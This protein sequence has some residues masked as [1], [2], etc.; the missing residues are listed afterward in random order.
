MLMDYVDDGWWWWL[1]DLYI[2]TWAAGVGVSSQKINFDDNAFD[3]DCDDT[4]RWWIM[5]LMMVMID[6]IYAIDIII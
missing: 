5:I 2:E 1:Y 4:Y 3:I 6:I